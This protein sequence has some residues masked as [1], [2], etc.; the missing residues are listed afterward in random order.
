[1]GQT[2]YPS[3]IFSFKVRQHGLNFLI[4][5]IRHIVSVNKI[6]ETILSFIGPND[7]SVYAIRDTKG[8]KLLK[9]LRL[10]FK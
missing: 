10:N 1:M 5:I 4:L 9:R 3:K 2:S 7:N 8:L 6:K